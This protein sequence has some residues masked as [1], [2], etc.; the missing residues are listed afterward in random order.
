MDHQDYMKLALQLAEGGK[1]Q[2]SPNPVVG[3]IVV[4]NGRIVGMGAHLKAGE[5]HAEV[6]ALNMADDKAKGSTVYVTLEPCSHYGKTPPCAELLIEKE[7][8]RVFIATM[9][10]NPQVS[11]RGI[12]MLKKAGVEVLTGLLKEQADVLNEKFF[13]YMK[14]KTPFVTMKSA[15]SLDGKIATATGESQWITGKEALY[16]VHRYREQ[17]D[18]ILVGVNTVIADNPKLTTRL[19]GGG[20]NPLRIILDHH[21]RTPYE[22]NVVQDG[23]AETWIVAGRSVSEKKRSR[24]EQ[25][26]VKILSVSEEKIEILPLLKR[27]GSEGITSLFV[28]GGATVND[29]FLRAGAAQE[30]V[31]Y[32]APKL[33]GGKS[34]PT[35]FAGIGIDSLQ[36]VPIFTFKSID[37]I[38]KDIKIISRPKERKEDV[39]RNY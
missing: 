31:S 20:K 39:Y 10:P 30:I 34:A 1:G 29:S 18:A 9:D 23:E 6:H 24:Y 26:G 25:H 14:T 37:Q 11:G 19:S 33:I 22:A 28:E 27:L 32:I 17:H 2:T 15:I 3:A 8:S 7:V 21:L 13:H 36:D 4:N 38:G 35:S 12:E 5:P 16:D